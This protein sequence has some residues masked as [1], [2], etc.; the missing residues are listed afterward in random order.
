MFLLRYLPIA[1]VGVPVSA[2][3]VHFT[4]DARGACL[5][6]APL[7]PCAGVGSQQRT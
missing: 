2:A 3:E 4:A 7:T 5:N 6:I 1:N